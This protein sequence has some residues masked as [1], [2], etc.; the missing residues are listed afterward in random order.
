MCKNVTVRGD[1]IHPM[2]PVGGLGG[3]AALYDANAPR[4]ALIAVSRSEQEL[5][6]ALAAYE[7]AIRRR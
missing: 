5:L 3:N 6:P 1:A 7:R 2:P 4:R